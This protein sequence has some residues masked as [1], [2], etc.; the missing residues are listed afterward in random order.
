MKNVLLF[1]HYIDR[2]NGASRSMLDLMLDLTEKKVANFII[3]YNEGA[4]DTINYIEEKGVVC[5]KVGFGRWDLADGAK[6]WRAKQLLKIL[7]GFIGTPLALINTYTLIKKYKVGIIYTN[8]TVLYIGAIAAWLF[9]VP[10]IWHVREF[11]M[12]DHR[13]EIIP[14]REALYGLMNLP[15]TSIIYISNS[16]REAYSLHVQHNEQ[17]VVY[18]DISR[19]FILSERSVR[20]EDGLL[21]IVVIGTISEGKRQLDAVKAVEIVS[22]CG[23]EVELHIAGNKTGTYYEKVQRY[24]LS[25]GLDQIVLFDGFITDTKNYRQNF[26]VGV[27]PS[28]KEAFGRVTVEGM[29]SGLLMVCSNSAGNTEIIENGVTGYL[30]EMGSY[31]DLAKI[32]IKISNDKK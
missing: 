24:V 28:E 30:Y 32:I 9:K 13:I 23:I 3:A 1:L 19:D 16:V 29:L 20:K 27:V 11:G 6:L 4:V 8:T 5:K 18:N 21:R 10:H 26:D 25:H 22:K 2:N 7:I 17:Y 15:N 31:V 12:E 14:S